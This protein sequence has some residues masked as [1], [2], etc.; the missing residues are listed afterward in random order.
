MKALMFDIDGTLIDSVRFD[1]NLY[2]KAVRTI[3]DNVLIQDDWKKYSR[4]TDSA[5]PLWQQRLI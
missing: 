5:I 3:L 2:I 1:A 4:V